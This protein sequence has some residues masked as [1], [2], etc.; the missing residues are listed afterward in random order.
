MTALPPETPSDEERFWPLTGA[1]AATF[2]LV[3]LLCCS[4]TMW[5]GLLALGNCSPDDSRPECAPDRLRIS[6]WAPAWGTSIGLA[7]A[8]IGCWI[9]PRHP[10]A[11]WLFFGSVVALLGFAAGFPDGHR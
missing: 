9:W 3:L 2:G 7:I 8:V 5:R 6:E 11:V 4:A 1:I 10:R